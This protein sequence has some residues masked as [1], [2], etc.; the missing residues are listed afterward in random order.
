MRRRRCSGAVQRRFEEALVAL[1]TGAVENDGFNRLVLAAGLSARQ[2]TVFRL[3]SKFLRQAGSAFSQAYMEDALSGHP[4]IAPRL[5]RLFEIRFD[6][7]RTGD[8]SLSIMGEVQ[9]IDHALDKV[10]SLDEDRILR[11]FLTLV[12]KT[13]RTNYFQRLP[14][15]EPKPYL[16][17][18]LASSEIDLMPMPRPLFEI[19]VYS[20]RVEAVHMRAGRVARGGIRWSDRK[21]D[22]RTEILGLMKAQTV[23]NAVIVPVGSKGGFVI[24]QP[25]ASTDKLGAE[26]VECYKTL[27]RGLLGPHRQHRRAD[28]RRRTGSCS[29]RGSSGMMAMTP[30]SWSPPIRAP[31]PSPISPTRS[32]RST[33]SGSAMRSRRAVRRGTTTRR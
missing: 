30:I 31:R 11:S 7:A 1:W 18:K 5:V 2:V 8:P 32:R 29:R 13:V 15:G 33:G 21:E 24:K 23:K 14:S 6:P 27:I 19:Y 12:L 26:A 16:A 22:F 20:P 3:Y 10:A 9:A 17:V 28:S 25:P 4:E